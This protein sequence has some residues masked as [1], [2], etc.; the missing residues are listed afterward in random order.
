MAVQA[1]TRTETVGTRHRRTTRLRVAAR[2][3]SRIRCQRG[4]TLVELLLVIL[5]SSV[6]LAV[7]LLFLRG[8]TTVFNSQQVRILNQDDARTAINQMTRYLRMATSSADNSTSLS[9]A[10]ATTLPA[11]IEFFCDADGD[12]IAEKLR[13]YLEGSVL[14]SQTEDPVWVT[15]TNPYWQY[16]QYD[17]DGVVIENRVR[18]ES[19]EPMFV[20]YRQGISGLEQFTPLTDAGR[21]EVVSVGILV[22]VGERPDLA[23]RDVFLSTEVQIRQR[24]NGGLDL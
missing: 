22:R 10:L 3:R 16:G 23:A 15:G 20:Y 21:R 4:F 6:L 11:D 9:N 2:M 24:F 1:S 13:Y 19:G 8:T 12:G 7:G 17:T 14:R 18:N 5:I